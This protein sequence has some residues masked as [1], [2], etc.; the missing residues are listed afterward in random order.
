MLNDPTTIS[1]VARLIGETLQ[2]DYGIDPESMY[3]DSRINP[4]KFQTPGS[5]VPFSKM[6][7]LWRLATEASQ[8]PAFGIKVG[9]RVKPGDFYVLGHAWLASETLLDAFRRLA[10]FIKVLSTARN[11]LDIRIQG[12]V[13]ALV[14][15]CTDL[16]VQPQ[17]SAMDAGFAALVRMCDLVT[18]TPIRPRR[19][20]LPRCV[21]GRGV[22]Y[23][24]ALG[25][26]VEFGDLEVWEFSK[27]DVETTLT[28]SIPDVASAVE[29]IAD[30][31]LSSLAEGA[32]THEVREM[33]V[34]MMP[35]GRSDQET[36]AKRL[37]RSRSTLQ[38][39]LGAE[40]T[41]YR[42]ILE[43]TRR[44]LAEQYLRSKDY[45]QAEVAFMLG[46]TDQSNFARAFRRWTGMSPGE[47]RKAA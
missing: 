40:G 43:S 23:P 20:V 34:Q 19:V 22:D 41:S 4:G 21:D 33:L 7:M 11:S 9:F 18:A 14:D 15:N 8:D 28:G 17:P 24:A 26:P 25:C 5:R 2:E 35:S 29:S 45:S 13:V 3:R 27:A 30:A 6:N 47:F 38:R 36:V 10:R 39:Q 1:S 46:F 12:D 32:V 44:S 16:E 31:Y 42:Q 37:Y